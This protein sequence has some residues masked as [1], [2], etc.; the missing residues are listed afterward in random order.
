M[1][2]NLLRQAT[3]NLAI[4]EWEYFNAKFNYNNTP[5]GPLGISVIVHTKIG[6]QQSWDFRGKDGWSVGVSMTHYR[7][8]H[9]I[10]KLT[11]SMMISDTTEF[12]HHHITQTSVTPEDR[13]LHGL[14]Q[15]T[16]AIQGAPYSQSGD[17]I[18]ALQSLKDTR[19]WSP[20]QEYGAPWIA[21]V[22]YWSPWSTLSSGV[23]D[24]WVMWWCLNSV[25]SE[26]IIDLVSFGITRWQR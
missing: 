22:N 9:V 20:D 21:A 5:L 10:P 24:G 3:A 12:R 4:S 14:Q 6:R 17:Q 11:R 26:I 23:I 16:A 13:V 15:L 8:Q 25:V 7:C 1:T 19:I 18:R 2:L